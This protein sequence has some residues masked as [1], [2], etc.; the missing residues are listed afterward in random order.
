[1]QKLKSQL[2]RS[3]LNELPMILL[4]GLAFGLVSAAALSTIL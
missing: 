3:D 4:M 2:G 1:M